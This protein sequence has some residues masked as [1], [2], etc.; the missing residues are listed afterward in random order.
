MHYKLYIN[1]EPLTISVLDSLKSS[2]TGLI[3]LYYAFA[4]LN[5]LHPNNRNDTHPIQ[6]AT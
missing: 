5:Q 3:A 2:E 1:V 4:P 6:G